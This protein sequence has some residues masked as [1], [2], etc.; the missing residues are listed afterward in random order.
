MSVVLTELKVIG[1]VGSFLKSKGAAKA[2]LIDGPNG[3][4]VNATAA[5]GSKVFTLPVGKKSQ[6]A[7]LAELS[8]IET[9]DGNYIATAN[10]YETI[11]SMDL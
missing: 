7:T 1:S 11:E 6:G 9:A 8:V 10:K 4:W 2:Q 3:K 5:N